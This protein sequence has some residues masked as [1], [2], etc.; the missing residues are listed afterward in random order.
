MNRIGDSLGMLL[1]AIAA[2][3][4]GVGLG[5]LLWQL[6]TPTAGA[7]PAGCPIGWPVGE[8]PPDVVLPPPPPFP[9]LKVSYLSVVLR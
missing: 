1:I 9:H 7:A 5:L 2:A 4:I 3:V 6:V 8:C